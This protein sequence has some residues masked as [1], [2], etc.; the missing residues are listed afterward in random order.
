MSV[1]SHFD[2]A[3]LRRVLIS[4]WVLHTGRTLRRDVPPSELP[5]EELIDFWADPLLDE[6]AADDPP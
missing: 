4:T 3:L 1:D 6:P 5:V 2:D